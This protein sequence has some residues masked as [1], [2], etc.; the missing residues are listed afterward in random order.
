MIL[1]EKV[2]GKF[3]PI[4][5]VTIVLSK[6]D[7]DDGIYEINPEVYKEF[8]NIK[9]I[10]IENVTSAYQLEILKSIERLDEICIK[11]CDDREI[12]L[13]KLKNYPS[14]KYITALTYISDDLSYMC[15]NDLIKFPKLETE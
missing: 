8:A 12:I 5:D 4:R 14:V 7:D 9:K 10:T 1:V 13:D 2:K 11:V 6:E 3:T 15:S